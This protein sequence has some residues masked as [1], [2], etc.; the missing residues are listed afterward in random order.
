MHNYAD[1]GRTAKEGRSELVADTAR[2]GRTDWFEGDIF[3]GLEVGDLLCF[4]LLSGLL[5]GGFEDLVV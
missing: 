3:G 5:G 1:G 2:R 4:G